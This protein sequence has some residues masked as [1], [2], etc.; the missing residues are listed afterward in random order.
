MRII[1][2][3]LGMKFRFKMF[4]IFRENFEKRKRGFQT[5]PSHV[6]TLVIAL[7]SRSQNFFLLFNSVAHSFIFNFPFQFDF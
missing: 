5:V 3:H 7:Q 4:F 1:V 6:L 2:P